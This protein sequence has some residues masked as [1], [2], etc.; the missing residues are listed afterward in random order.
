MFN[1]F[2]EL[3]SPEATQITLRRME[4]VPQTSTV[5]CSVSRSHSESLTLL[6]SQPVLLLEKMPG[7]E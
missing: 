3:N 4:Y 7:L 5:G 2:T 1:I 6:S